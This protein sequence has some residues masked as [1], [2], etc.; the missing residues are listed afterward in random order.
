MAASRSNGISRTV[1]ARARSQQRGSP[2][3]HQS[4][5]RESHRVSASTSRAHTPPSMRS[6]RRYLSG[7][8]SVPLEEI[9]EQI[10][11]P[12]HPTHSQPRGPDGRTCRRL[13]WPTAPCPSR[14]ARARDRS[15]ATL[16]DGERRRFHT[17]RSADGTRKECP[18]GGDG[19]RIASLR[20]DRKT[21]AVE[22]PPASARLDKHSIASRI[23]TRFAT[24]WG[25]TCTRTLP[26]SLEERP[27]RSTRCMISFTEKSDR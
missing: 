20:I 15:W 13:H 22:A 4:A 17:S 26:L 7:A 2:R 8:F 18:R 24:Q 6:R 21:G 12:E 23:G 9:D 10:R 14:S 11:I 16:A 5:L 27:S 19:L 1:S 3:P 25:M